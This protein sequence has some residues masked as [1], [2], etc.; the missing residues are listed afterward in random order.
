MKASEGTV[1]KANRPY[2]VKVPEIKEYVFT[3]ENEDG[4]T[5]KKKDDNSILYLNTSYYDFYFYGT[6][7]RDVK[8]TT[9]E[10]KWLGI[11]VNGNMF[12]NKNSTSMT[13]ASAYR[14]YI[15]VTVRND[16]YA[17]PNF[18]FMEDEGDTDG[19]NNT[20]VNY[21]E[22]EG[23]YTLGGM[24]V[25]HPVKGVNIIKYTDGRTKKI[26]VK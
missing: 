10:N 1:L 14:W 3:V 2:L 19:I 24:K 20:K 13:I 15:M 25:E 21:D 12:W 6:Y 8:P 22:I 4:V 11:N 9:D 17:K 7:L 16:G 18:G 5:L 26:N 23:I